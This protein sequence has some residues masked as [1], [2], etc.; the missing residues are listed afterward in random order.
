MKLY[1]IYDLKLE[2]PVSKWI[3]FLKRGNKKK[4]SFKQILSHSAG[5][6]PYISHQNLVFNNKVTLQISLNKYHINKEEDRNDNHPTHQ[7]I[8]SLFNYRGPSMSLCMRLPE[9]SEWRTFSN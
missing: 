9:F 6:I 4:H 5:W 7:K 8:D 2:D 3:P 1:E